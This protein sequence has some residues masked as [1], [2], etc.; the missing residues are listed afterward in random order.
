MAK[1]VFSNEYQVFL[2]LLRA[3]RV[4]AGLTQEDLAPRLGMTQSAISK[5]ERVERRLDVVELRRWCD[6]LGTRL[7]RFVRELDAAL[8]GRG[9]R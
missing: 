2:K 5:C 3:A 6:A 8:G 4:K 1:S 7:D 9:L